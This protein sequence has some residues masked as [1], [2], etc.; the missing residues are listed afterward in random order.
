MLTYHWRHKDRSHSTAL[1]LLLYLLF[2]T[3]FRT[4]SNSNSFTCKQQ[5]DEK[6]L[7]FAHTDGD[8]LSLLNVYHA[9]K[10]V[11]P[12]C[13]LFFPIYLPYPLSSI[14]FFTNDPIHYWEKKQFSFTLPFHLLY[15]VVLCQWQFFLYL[16]INYL[17]QA[18]QQK[19]WCYENFINYRSLQS[20]DSVR[21]QLARIMR[22][23]SLPLFSTDFN[24]IKYYQNLRRCIAAGLFMQV[25]H[26]I[27]HDEKLQ[28][29]YDLPMLRIRFNRLSVP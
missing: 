12:F 28:Y 24:S 13:Y 29:A 17:P 16:R 14:Y 25:C 19:E 2:V 5:A 6:K 10:Q 1:S 9:Y 18:S 8:H 23:L 21:D 20:A 3:S 26:P 27:K 11:S 4:Q 15:I 7:Q 22:K